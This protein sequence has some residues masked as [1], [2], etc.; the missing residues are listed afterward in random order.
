MIKS[1]LGVVLILVAALAF[2]GYNSVFAVSE[3]KQVIVLQFGK[4][5]RVVTSPGLNFKLPFVE[6]L[7]SYDDRVL[8]LDPP[9]FEVLLTDKK[10]I[11]VDGFARFRISRPVVFFQRVRT[12]ER[13]RDLFGKNM[14]SAMR[15]VIATVSLPQ[16]LGPGRSTV[17]ER[18]ISE[19]AP[20]AETL[21][22]KVLDVRVGRTDLPSQTSEAVFNRMRTEREREAR[23]ARAEGRELAQKIRA[24]ADKKRVVIQA[25]ANRRADILR[26]EGEAG[27]TR[28]LAEAYSRDPEFFYFYKSMQE[29]DENLN[30]KT[31]MVVNPNSSEF[32]RF[33]SS[34]LVDSQGRD[35]AR[36]ANDLLDK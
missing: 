32:F 28:I 27:R 10:R 36:V 8:D 16:L 33:F 24:L 21:G 25:E 20:Q 7:I 12:E 19:V 17:M 9:N 1:K 31:T 2:V 35:P 34:P 14:N 30:D 23:E 3:T 26:G 22:I 15:R 29:Y 6:Q 5:K 13:L 18:I 4:V 11:I